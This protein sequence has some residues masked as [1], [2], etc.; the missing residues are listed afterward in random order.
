MGQ[1]PPEAVPPFDMQQ[2]RSVQQIAGKG[3]SP[4]GKKSLVF[5]GCRA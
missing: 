5:A 4:L 2:H 1:H 3:G